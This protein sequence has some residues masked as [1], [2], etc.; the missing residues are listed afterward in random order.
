VDANPPAIEAL[1]SPEA[2]A[3]NMSTV[4]AER[5]LGEPLNMST[6]TGPVHAPGPPTVLRGGRVSS[7]FGELGGRVGPAEPSGFFSQRRLDIAGLRNEI[8][9]KSTK[10][11]EAIA[12]FLETFSKAKEFKDRAESLGGVREAERGDTT[13]PAEP[14]IPSSPQMQV[15]QLNQA[16]TADL[17]LS[18]GKDGER[19]L[20]F[21][22]LKEL[23]R[24]GILNLVA[25]L[26]TQRRLFG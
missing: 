19:P 26:R 17:G 4:P 2:Q 24:S 20:T 15:P 10:R 11:G 13:L 12:D 25:D 16:Q 7:E 6:A 9:T 21:A 14:S 1:L 5:S 3:A 8:A 23:Q 22:E 18:K